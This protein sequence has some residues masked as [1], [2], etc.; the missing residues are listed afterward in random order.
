MST[1]KHK[2]PTLAELHESD[3]EKA[4]KNDQLLLLL[5]SPPNK[6][7]LKKHPT[8]KVKNEKRQYVELEYLPTDKLEFLLNKIFGRWHI[9]IQREGVMFNSVYVAVRLHYWNP[10]TEEWGYKDGIGAVGAQTDAGQAAGNLAAIKQDA[11][12]K[13]LPAAASYAF[14]NACK[15]LGAIFGGDLNN[16]ETEEF[17]PTFFAPNPSPTPTPL[18]PVVEAEIAETVLQVEENGSLSTVSDGKIQF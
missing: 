17:T 3:P 1:L 11:I 18:Q 12:M 4:Y 14:K 10:A 13:A 7:W 6:A 5:S 2:L 8:I 15:R 9:E 16:F